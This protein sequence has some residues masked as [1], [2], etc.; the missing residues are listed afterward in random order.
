MLRLSALR[1]IRTFAEER[2]HQVPI[3]IQDR[4]VIEDTGSTVDLIARGWRVRNYPERLAYSATPPDFGALIIQRRRWSNGGLIILPDLL[5]YLWANPASSRT[6]G[7]A[8]MR[9]YY[10]C[11]PALGSFALLA[12]LLYRFEDSFLNFWLP[13]AAIPYYFLY[14]RDLRN[15]GYSW[16]DLLRVYGLNLLLIPVNLAGVLR[17]LQ[18]L[19]TGRKAAFGRTPK[20]QFRTPVPP[21]YIAF[22]LVLVSYLTVFGASDVARGSYTHAGFA[23]G[24]AFA[25]IYSIGAFI[26]WRDSLADLSAWIASGGRPVRGISRLIRWRANWFT[27]AGKPVSPVDET[28]LSLTVRPGILRPQN[29]SHNEFGEQVVLP[30]VRV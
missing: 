14:G 10:L 6:R 7:E 24:N 18:Q 28:P 17:S 16:S 29:F 25:L 26:G 15:C 22:L 11:S 20:I 5:R 8:A 2:G 9:I 4:T 3:F 13:L 23:F 21:I 1:D 19:L 27:R 12:L 30:D